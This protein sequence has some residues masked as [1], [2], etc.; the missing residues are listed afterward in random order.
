[1]RVVMEMIEV[2]RAF[3]SYQKMIHSID[4]LNEQAISKVGKIA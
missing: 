3:E 2:L 4:D 1:M